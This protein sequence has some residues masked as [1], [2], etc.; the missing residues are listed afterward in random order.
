MLALQCSMIGSG[1]WLPCSCCT[2]HSFGGVGGCSW[3]CHVLEG[4]PLL[5]RDLAEAGSWLAFPTS[6][7][8]PFPEL[9]RE[10]L[11][12]LWVHLGQGQL[13]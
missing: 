5:C 9:S 7:T 13:F 4:S 2:Q 3:A 6:W 11:P 10:G 12:L 1:P 8:Q